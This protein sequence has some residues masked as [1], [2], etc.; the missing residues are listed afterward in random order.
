MGQHKN[1]ARGGT[2][3]QKGTSPT[4]SSH[5]GEA[6]DTGE[7]GHDPRDDCGFTGGMTIPDGCSIQDALQIQ[8]IEPIT[9]QTISIT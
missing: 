5:G 2:T 1:A 3:A 7:A 9:I 4:L 8:A 6:G